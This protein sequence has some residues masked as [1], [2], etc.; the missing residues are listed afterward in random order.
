LVNLHASD[1][2][3]AYARKT[4]TGVVVAVIN[5]DDKGAQ[6]D[7]DVSP[8]RLAN[9]TVLDDLLE[10]AKR[11]MVENGKL[12]VSLPARSAALFIPR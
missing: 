3:Y 7:F 2:Q 6:I 9:G 5:N 1:Q 4:T 8:L 12:K 10:V 11:G